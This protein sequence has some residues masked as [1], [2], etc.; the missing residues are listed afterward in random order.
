MPMPFETGTSRRRRP[1]LLLLIPERSPPS[2]VWYGSATRPTR[3]L[4]GASFGIAADFAGIRLDRAPV[5]HLD[6]VRLDVRRYFS[7]IVRRRPI[8]SFSV[9]TRPGS[10]SRNSTS[11]PDD[12]RVE[13][14]LHQR[15][16]LAGVFSTSS[17]WRSIS[18]SSSCWDLTGLEPCR[19]PGALG[20]GDSARCSGGFTS[21]RPAVD[22]I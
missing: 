3:E 14:A 12:R 6:L 1:A 17:S 8:M 20:V 15:R 13:H 2:S 21:R 11:A 5:V 22:A 10:S 4:D 16:H 7:E 9:L 18:A 19:R